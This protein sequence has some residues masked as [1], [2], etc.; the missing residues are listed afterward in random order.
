MVTGD[1]RPWATGDH[2][3]LADFMR[4]QRPQRWAAGDYGAQATS[5][6]AARRRIWAWEGGF[7]GWGGGG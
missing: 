4:D 5:T 6:V 3:N 7:E 1:G 2:G